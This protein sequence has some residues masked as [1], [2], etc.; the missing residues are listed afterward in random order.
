VDEQNR[1]QIDN[2]K[3]AGNARRWV[4]PELLRLEAGTAEFGDFVNADAQPGLS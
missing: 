2:L 4:R 3:S 1:K